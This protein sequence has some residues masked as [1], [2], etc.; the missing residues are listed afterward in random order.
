MFVHRFFLPLI[1]FNVPL[2]GFQEIPED[3]PDQLNY[4]HVLRLL[5]VLRVTSREYKRRNE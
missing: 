2:T 3:Y 4:L 1:Q 5:N